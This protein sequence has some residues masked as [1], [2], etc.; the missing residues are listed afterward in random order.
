MVIDAPIVHHRYDVIDGCHAAALPEPDPS[1][2]RVGRS[3]ELPVCWSGCPVEPGGFRLPT[4]RQADR[5]A[6]V[7]GP[8]GADRQMM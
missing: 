8:I 1:A 6:R 5:A 7:A 3:D 2:G 4:D